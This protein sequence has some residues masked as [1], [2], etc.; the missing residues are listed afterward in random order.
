MTRPRTQLDIVV[1][2]RA[3]QLAVDAEVVFAAFETVTAKL[4]S[5][6][7]STEML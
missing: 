7:M 6:H 1:W 4:R 3:V 5:A 2:L